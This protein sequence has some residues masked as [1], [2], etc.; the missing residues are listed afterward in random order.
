VTAVVIADDHG[1]FRRG[2]EAALTAA[3]HDVLNSVADGDAALAAVTAANPD[4]L[5]LDLRMPGRDGLSTLQAL[6]A[7][8]DMRPVIVLAAEIEDSVLVALM[9]ARADAILLKNGSE[10][11]LFDALRAVQDGTRFYDADLIDRAFAAMRPPWDEKLNEREIAICREVA[12]GLRNREIAEKLG[13]T[14][15]TVKIYLHGVFAKLD[16]QTRAEL[17]AIVNT[18]DPISIN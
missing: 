6:R 11:R 2:L 10:F 1:L 4:V 15:S 16:L 18:S 8:G 3:G 5:V 9:A 13:M 14:I 12:A 7:R 17:A